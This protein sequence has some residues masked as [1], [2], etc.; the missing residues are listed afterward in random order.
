M[1]TRRPTTSANPN[2]FN[3]QRQLLTVS[4]FDARPRQCPVSWIVVARARSRIARFYSGRIDSIDPSVGRI[5][6]NNERIPEVDA[7]THT[8]ARARVL[9]AR[10]LAW[11]PRFIDQQHV[12]SPATIRSGWSAARMP[13]ACH[14]GLFLPLYRSLFPPLRPCTYSEL[15]IFCR[16]TFSRRVWGHLLLVSHLFV[17][18]K[19]TVV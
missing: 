8:D 17:L 4:T 14:R 18:R 9:R 19:T 11:C 12:C 5:A 7:C 10:V 6:R 16:G 13:A 3:F 2:R 1:H 15:Y